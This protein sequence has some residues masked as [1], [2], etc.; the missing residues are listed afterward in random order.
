DGSASNNSLDMF[1]EMK[2][3][4]LLHKFSNNN[5]EVASAQQVFDMATRGGAKVLG[6][7]KEIGSIEAGKQADIVLVNL[8]DISMIPN[9]NPVSNI[10]YSAN[11]SCVNTTIVKGRI[12]MEN[13]ILKTIDEEK[14][15][16]KVNK[17]ASTLV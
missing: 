2:V 7:D 1:T 16:D 9:H 5:P 12:L 4:A 11:G 17:F 13:R 14:V 6:L 3:C 8:K 15:T 10:V